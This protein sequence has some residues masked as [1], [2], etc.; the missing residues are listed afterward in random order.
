[1]LN[2]IKLDGKS[3]IKSKFCSGFNSSLTDTARIDMIDTDTDGKVYVPSVDGHKY[4]LSLVEE[5]SRYTYVCPLQSKSN[6]PDELQKFSKR[7]KKQSGDVFQAFHTDGGAEFNWSLL[8]SITEVSNRRI[9]LP[10]Y[11]SQTGSLCV[12]TASS[13]G[14]LEHV[15]M[16]LGCHRRTGIIYSST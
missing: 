5:F 13:W 6:V 16:K 14:M 4:S 3:C 12:R 8:F 10:T 2:C 1:M 9:R 15:I 11:R 7:F